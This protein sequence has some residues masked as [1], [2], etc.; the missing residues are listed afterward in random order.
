MRLFFMLCILCS[1]VHVFSQTPRNSALWND[2]KGYWSFNHPTDL[3]YDS[4]TY[5]NPLVPKGTAPTRVNAYFP[6]DYAIQTPAASRQNHLR[7]TPK[8][9]AN[10]GG[11]KVNQYTLLLD[12][13]VP[14]LSLWYSLLQTNVSPNADDGD[15]F[16]DPNGKIGIGGAGYSTRQIEADEWVRIVFVCDNNTTNGVW[17][18]FLDGELQ[19]SLGGQGID[20]RFA[21]PTASQSFYF[22]ADDGTENPPLQC[23]GIALWSKTLTDKEVQ[24]IGGYNEP[25]SVAYPIQ[26]FLQT[27]T[28]HSIY[29]S[30]L[31]DAKNSSIINYG[32]QADN[33]HIQKPASWESI[34][35][36]TWHT[37][38][39]EN[40]TPSTTYYYQCVSGNDSSL[41]HSFRTPPVAGADEKIIIAL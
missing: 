17:K 1:W 24:A 38:K 36:Y 10:G 15:I 33:L 31:N 11:T 28:S 25:T 34:S 39:L 3:W 5:N 29:V 30:W 14:T 13:K 23:A 22:F 26:P 9:A 32:T 12:I 2:V 21:L 20:G 4:S 18:I 6:D 19:V 27:P 37:V 41:V 16:V 7:C 40:L 8:L 35:D